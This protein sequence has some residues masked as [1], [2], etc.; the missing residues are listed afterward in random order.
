VLNAEKVL[1]CTEKSG[2]DNLSLFKSLQLPGSA[3]ARSSAK[4]GASSWGAPRAGCGGG[5]LCTAHCKTLAR[6]KSLVVRS[7][8][9][10]FSFKKKKLQQ[11]KTRKI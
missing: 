9:L 8:I 2:P 5:N 11:N 1:Q 4:F 10:G 6:K 7:V 3:G